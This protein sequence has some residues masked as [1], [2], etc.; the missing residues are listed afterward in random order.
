MSENQQQEQDVEYD[1][2]GEI[3]K[4]HREID[5]KLPETVT[6]LD[7]PLNGKVYVIGT[8]HFSVK[9][10]QEVKDV[11]FISNHYYVFNLFFFFF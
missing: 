2:S 7:A 8:A 9:S 3:R 4:L 6:V 10:Q 11:S 5:L 1:N